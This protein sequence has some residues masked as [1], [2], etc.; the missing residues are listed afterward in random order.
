MNIQTEMEELESRQT[1]ILKRITQLELS[2][3]PPSTDEQPN[4]TVARL[5]AALVAGAVKDFSFK[6]VPSD[7][8]DWSLEARRDVLGA[9]SI[10]H[11]CKSIVLVTKCESQ[12]EASWRALEAWKSGNKSYLNK[13]KRLFQ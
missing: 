13:R 4:A 6:R 11:L 7:Y 5:S 1:Q 9:A 12:I 3:L 2:L 10:H 8:Y